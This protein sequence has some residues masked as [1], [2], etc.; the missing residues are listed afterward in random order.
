MGVV[1]Q[2]ID[3]LRY[4]SEGVLVLEKTVSVAKDGWSGQNDT[5]EC[6]Q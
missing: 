4:H 6:R 1:G 3:I 2:A 5:A